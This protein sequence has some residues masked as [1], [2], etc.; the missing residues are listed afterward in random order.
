M[1]R[2]VTEPLRLRLSDG[3]GSRGPSNPEARALYVKGR[4]AYKRFGGGSVRDAVETFKEANERFPN[5]AWI[6][7]AFGSA[8]TR[9]WMINGSTD[10][11]LIV[12]AEELSLRALAADPTIGETFNT[13]GMLRLNSGELRAAV[14]A[15]QEAT[16]RSPQLAEAHEYL[17]RL[18]CECGHVE[19]GIL[20][21][22][23]A[24]RLDATHLG[25]YWEL[26]RVH[27]LLG[28]RPKAE[29]C[30]A[31]ITAPT[32]SGMAGMLQRARL[33]FWWD[34]SELALSLA[35]IMEASAEP[36]TSYLRTVLLPI[37]QVLARRGTYDECIDAFERFA[38]VATP[39][40]RQRAF[41]QQLATEFL[42]GVGAPSRALAALEGA[43]ELPL[44]DVFWLDRCPVLGPIR[45]DPR[46]AKV[47]ALVAQR[48]AEIWA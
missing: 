21:L 45:D 3:A 5:D 39:S 34:D 8:L 36:N 28:D 47:R 31:K 13:I 6:M 30:I 1:V 29:E 9:L 18:L 10:R 4:N 14:R 27:A 22:E 2:G 19:E 12:R 7:S 37:I 15:F 46:F 44:I 43:A 17:G 48:A 11:D 26:A 42:C 35:A 41:L 40:S 23:Q 38:A 25:A 20:R 33:A 24:L 32:G 16:R